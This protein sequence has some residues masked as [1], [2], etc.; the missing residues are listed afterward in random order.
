MDKIILDL[1]KKY[2][3]HVNSSRMIPLDLDGLKPVERRVLLSLYEIAQSKFIKSARVVGHCMGHYHPHSSS[4]GTIVQ[5]V[6][7]GFATGQGNWGSYVG[8][9]HEPAAAERYTEIK[10]NK[11]FVDMAFK[12]VDYVPWCESDLDKEPQF[13]P[14]RFPICLIGNMYSS[15]IGFGYKTSIPCY[16]MEDLLKRLLFLLKIN[17]E[18]IVIK[19]VTNCD[20]LSSDDELKKLLITGKNSVQFKGRFIVDNLRFTVNLKSWPESISFDSIIKK[21]EKRTSILPDIDITDYSDESGTNIEFRVTKQKNKDTIFRSLVEK[22]DNAITGSANFDIIVTDL[23]GKV[24]RT[25]VDELLL[26]TYR[27]Y[28]IITKNMLVSEKKRNENIRDE[29]ISLEKIRPFVG[30]LCQN[31]IKNINE[32]EESVTKISEQS[33][34]QIEVVK[35]LISKYRINKLLTTFIDVEEV[36]NTITAIEDNIKNLNDYVL[37]EYIK[38]N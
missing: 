17:N 30:N 15:G 1:Y 20:I 34:V 12:L 18:D 13:L 7:Q 14:V 27:M 8:I 33:G 26:N 35:S 24:R 6:R 32:L 38:E 21:L 31:K 22:I 36:S 29:Y 11:W 28:S 23:D 4:Y 9:D 3:Q 19:P 2:G 16:K 25:C 37:N 5:M 10:L